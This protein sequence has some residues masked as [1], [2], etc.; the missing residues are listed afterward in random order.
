MNTYIFIQLLL[1]K[2]RFLNLVDRAIAPLLSLVT[3]TH[4]SLTLTFDY[5]HHP[6]IIRIWQRSCVFFGQIEVKCS[7]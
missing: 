6:D 3:K 1:M 5:N 4:L 7:G 2:L